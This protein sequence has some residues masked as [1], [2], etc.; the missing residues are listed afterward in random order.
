MGGGDILSALFNGRL[1]HQP[2]SVPYCARRSHPSFSPS[3][4]FWSHF[5]FLQVARAYLRQ[6]E[7]ANAEAQLVHALQ[8]NPS[9]PE[10]YLLLA[11]VESHVTRDDA[12]QYDTVTQR[13]LQEFRRIA[14]LQQ[15]EIGRAS[16]RE[17]V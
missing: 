13:K 2:S 4:F 7:Y 3:F 10:A 12:A 17:R 8:L 9:C 15:A 14:Q 6:G 16:C 11:E 1:S 5:H